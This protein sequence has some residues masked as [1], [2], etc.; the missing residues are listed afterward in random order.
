MSDRHYELL[1]ANPASPRAAE[2]EHL[3]D[4]EHATLT[5]LDRL[6]SYTTV[7]KPP[8]D[9]SWGMLYSAVSL[10]KQGKDHKEEWAGAAERGTKIH[11]L[12][13]DLALFGKPEDI[14]AWLDK[15]EGEMRGYAEALLGWFTTFKPF[16]IKCEFVVADLE[17]GVAGRADYF[18]KIAKQDVLIDWKTVGKD[19]HITKYERGFLQNNTELVARAFAMRKRGVKVDACWVVRL[20]PSGVY[21]VRPIPKEEEDGLFQS[22]LRARWEWE[23]RTKEKWA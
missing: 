12:A 8:G 2:L 20:A 14:N 6:P 21:H 22:F 15:Q 9:V 16:T 4:D 7:S 10:A 11:E 17:V 5:V 13:Q 23:F 3:I 19:D 18:A 1:I